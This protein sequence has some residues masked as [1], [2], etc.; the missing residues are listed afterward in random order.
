MITDAPPQDD[1]I[2][3]LH[4]ESLFNV[5]Q[6]V[7]DKRNRATYVE[8]A[9]HY[10]NEHDAVQL[11]H[12][13]EFIQGLALDAQG[14]SIKTD[15]AKALSSEKSRAAAFRAAANVATWRTYLSDDCVVAM[16]NDGWH[17]ST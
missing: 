2:A 8:P 3:A 6:S 9:T 13:L 11:R 17:R 16:I 15:M 4:L 14:L 7:G 1:L 5:G 12:R 10:S